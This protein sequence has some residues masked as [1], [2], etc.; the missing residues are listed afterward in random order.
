MEARLGVARGIG[1]QMDALWPVRDGV[2]LVARQ[3]LL[4]VV[5]A[6]LAHHHHG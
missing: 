1:R 6:A 2:A 3:G 5:A 4:P